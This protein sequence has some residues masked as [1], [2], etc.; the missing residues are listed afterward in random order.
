MAT[1]MAAAVLLV[2]IGTAVFF[3]YYNTKPA[4]VRGALVQQTPASPAIADHRYIRLPDGSR[5]LLNAGSQL[6]YPNSFGATREVHLTG[7]GYFDIRHD[8]TKPFIVVAGNTKTVVL[9]TA[10]DIK[11]FPGESNVVVTVTRGKVRVEKDNKTVGVLVRNEQLVVNDNNSSPVKETV[12][13]NTAI[14][15]KQD[16]ILLDDARLRDAA[17]DL[18]QRF[19]CSI[20]FN[21]PA[22]ENCRVTASF[23]H[24][25]TLNQIIQVLARIN[26][27]S[28]RFE[29]DSTIMLSGEGCPD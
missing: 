2:A 22:L 25:E 9:G 18:E 26:S 14:A 12:N 28:Y 27:M 20:S 17:K 6:Q 23:L 3:Y 4:P 10:F 21:Q 7:E 1:Y 5:V 8:A 13:T 29:N 19:H 15:W 11:A 24:H 16:D